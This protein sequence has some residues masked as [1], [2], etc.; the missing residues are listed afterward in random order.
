VTYLV[1]GFPRPVPGVPVGGGAPGPVFRRMHA[2]FQ[3][4]KPKATRAAEPGLPVFATRVA[5]TRNTGS[6]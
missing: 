6:A 3:Q 2:T 1:G 4:K 5:K